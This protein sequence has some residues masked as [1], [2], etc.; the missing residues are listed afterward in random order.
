MFAQGHLYV[1]VAGGC[2]CF[3]SMF[4]LLSM[5]GTFTPTKQATEE[6]GL[7]ALQNLGVKQDRLIGRRWRN[8]PDLG[9]NICPVSVCQ[10]ELETPTAPWITVKANRPRNTVLILPTLMWLG[11]GE[12]CLR[13]MWDSGDWGR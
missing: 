2:A 3:P 12:G 5:C 11:G 8:Q 7:H 13:N 10:I 6:R 9:G 1:T 4:L